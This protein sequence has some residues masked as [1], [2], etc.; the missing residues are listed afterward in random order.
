MLAEFHLWHYVVYSCLYNHQNYDYNISMSN[1]WCNM[2][3]YKKKG[4]FWILQVWL[5]V[6][7]LPS[8]SLYVL[9][10]NE[11]YLMEILSQSKT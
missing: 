11:R 7:P 9:E 8:I 3:E 4:K 1:L 10:Y 6:L 2:H 5:F